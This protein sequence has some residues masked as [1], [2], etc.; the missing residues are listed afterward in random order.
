MVMLRLAEELLYLALRD[1]H[2]SAGFVRDHHL[3]C[4]L[5]G[6]VLMDLALEDRIDSD[7]ERLFVVDATPLGDNILDPSLAMIAAERGNND[8]G[9]WVRRLSAPEIIRGVRDCAITR[10]IERGIIERDDGGLLSVTSAVSRARRYPGISAP[11]ALDAEMRVMGMIFSDEVP[12]PR[13]VM[14]IAI[15]DACGLLDGHLSSEER[16]Q[17]ADRLDMIRH[18]DLVGREVFQQIEDDQA[19]GDR[20]RRG[21]LSMFT[22]LLSRGLRA[23]VGMFRSGQLATTPVLRN[24]DTAL[25]DMPSEYQQV[26][27][28]RESRVTDTP[29]RFAEELLILTI[30][31]ENREAVHIPN[32]TF[33]YALTGAIL[34]DL[35]LENRIDTDLEALHLTNKAPVGDSLLDP[36]LAEI[37]D[38]PQVL[39]T[40]SWIARI[41][42]WGDDLSAQARDRLVARGVLEVDE[43]GVF[44][45][46]RW[47]SRTRRYPSVKGSA[48]QEVHSRMM[49]LLLSNEVP[50]PRDSII[51]S[52]AHACGL[53]RR[54]LTDNEYSEVSE[55]IELISR[56]EL[57]PRATAKALRDVS[58]AESQRLR[59]AIREAGGGWPKASGRLPL[60]GH[61]FKLSGDLQAFLTEQY[62]KHGPVF[63]VSA[64]GSNYVVLA[65]RDANL[66]VNKEGRFHLRTHE[67][68]QKFREWMGT[69]K[70][71]IALDGPDHRTLRRAKSSGYSRK[72]ILGRMPEAVAVAERELARLPLDRPHSVVELMQNIM[73]EQV[74]LLATGTS[75]RGHMADLSAF[76]SA[77]VKVSFK[78]Y[79]KLLLRTPKVKRAHRRLEK[80][81]ERVLAEH[82]SEP[83]GAHRPD[84]IDELIELHRS[85]PDFLPETDMFINPMGPFMVAFDT[86]ALSTSFALHALLTHPHLLDRVRTESDRLFADGEP[87]AEGLKQM[88]TTR[89]VIMETMRFYP[90]SSALPRRVTNSFEFAGYRIP[91]GTDVMLAHGVPHRLPEFFP[92]PERFD[93]DRFSP[94]RSEHL[95]RGVYCPFGLGHHTC[96]GQG[97]AEVQAFLTLATLLHRTEIALDPPNYRLKVTYPGNAR[98]D[99]RF[100]I[101]L[102][103]R[104]GFDSPRWQ[105][106]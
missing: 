94:A 7:P 5:A 55:R 67:A 1:D 19:E 3:R 63:E 29:L 62:L 22:R 13:D 77:I 84:M 58:L 35:A 27:E 34:M 97:F 90:M 60:F 38:E 11:Y 92:N 68:W 28:S 44:S 16:V 54:M 51:I 76:T 61:A 56:L 45:V 104:P 93:I 50:S 72:R 106:P 79:P 52:L 12:H 18:L 81:I 36:V 102:K 64:L 23:S 87:T 82:G 31:A 65:G 17:V 43:G 89:G 33:N 2:R 41:A 42:A 103:H 75:C 78:K 26:A 85:A 74:T 91:A 95:Q 39:T 66:F 47:V 57:V 14:L 69:S 20:D 71:L 24:T 25:L 59:R 105:H 10:L 46:S 15:V 83:D 70:L 6:S 73:T 40:E 100:R 37:A 48:G 86:V 99:H 30:D 32:R 98:P 80:L 21:G 9:Y 53:F 8:A 88:T 101:R 49:S 4:G 96:M